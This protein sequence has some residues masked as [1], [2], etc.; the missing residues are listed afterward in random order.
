[1]KGMRRYGTIIGAV[2]IAVCAVAI[3]ALVY[4]QVNLGT[5]GPLPP[6]EP[7]PDILPLSPLEN[8]GKRLIFD[9][10]LS[11]PPGYNCFTC[12][13]PSAGGT[14]G[15]VS[16]VNQMSG[17]Q[18]GVVPGRIGNRKPQ[19][20]AYATFS[21]E[22]PYYDGTIAMAYTG[23]AFWDGRVP[24]LSG[25]ARQPFLNP[26]EM[27]NTPTNGIYPG[28]A[29]GYSS[30]VAQKAITNWRGLFTQAYGANIIDRSTDADLY[31]MV[32][33]AIAA[34]EASGEL[35]QFSSK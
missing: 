18:P 7:T 17:P 21:P 32:C 16:I 22:G 26:N 3:P 1:M 28:V 6:A 13:V 25:Q 2:A 23:G 34:Y 35:N 30:L 29:G 31:T 33:D 4:A 20:Y 15:T 8:L 5:L 14:S 24:D 12:H 10:T 19:S 9:N 27:N 11:D